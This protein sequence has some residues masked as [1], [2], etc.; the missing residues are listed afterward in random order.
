MH[1]PSTRPCPALTALLPSRCRMLG[2]SPVRSSARCSRSS[3]ATR[4]SSAWTAQGTTTPPR[5]HG[6][7]SPAGVSGWGQEWEHQV[8]C[9]GADGWGTWTHRGGA[10]CLCYEVSTL[11]PQAR[12]AAQMGHTATMLTT[13]A[14]APCESGSPRVP[15]DW[16]GSHWTGVGSPCPWVGAPG[17]GW[18]P[19]PTAVMP[20]LYLMVGAVQCG[21]GRW[22]LKG[23][24]DPLTRVLPQ[25]WLPRD[26]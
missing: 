15:L 23:Y 26:F 3:T 9:H 7:G 1:L 25:Q 17:P 6:L 2:R 4:A 21:E 5:P 18:V 13:A 14:A 19:V 10:H 24:R 8:G 11:P 22:A 12:A 16:G 20:Q